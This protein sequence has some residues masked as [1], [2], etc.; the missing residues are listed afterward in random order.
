M[1]FSE[2][3]Q[4]LDKINSS[5]NILLNLHHNPDADSVG[6]ATAFGYFL[7]SINK[8]FKIITSSRPSKNLQFLFDEFGYE[9]VDF[10][11]FNY[12]E[13]DLFLVN[14]SSSWDRVAGSKRVEKPDIYFIVIDHHKTNQKFG[15]INLIV[16]HASA[17]SLLVYKLFKDWNIEITEK[18]ARSLL[19]GIYGDTGAL[20]FPEADVETYE[21]AL[22]LIKLTDK[23][24]IIYNLYQSF[25]ISHVKVWKEIMQNLEVDT[26]HKFAFSFIPKNIMEENGNPLN[27]KAEIAD[28]LFQSID[29]TDFGLIGAESEGY[30]SVSF[31]ARNDIDVS[32]LASRLGGGGH[33]WASAARVWEGDYSKTV[34]KILEEARNFAKENV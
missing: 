20:R 16:D 18:I 22:Q 5:Q 21:V 8:K 23:D 31:R 34:E 15:D 19:S 9:V 6:S 32:A 28:M 1:N 25:E 14:D 26:D 7:K 29:N 2:S 13:F 12:S 10:A 11:N 3:Q 24:Q 33:K 17:N 4:I 27:A 30:I